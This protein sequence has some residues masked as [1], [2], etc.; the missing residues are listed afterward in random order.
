MLSKGLLRHSVH[1]VLDKTHAAVAARLFHLSAYA[2][3]FATPPNKKPA[4]EIAGLCDP[5][6]IACGDPLRIAQPK[7]FA[8]PSVLPGIFIFSA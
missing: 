2:N 4:I 8:T 5:V 7:A 1:S 3:K 6:R